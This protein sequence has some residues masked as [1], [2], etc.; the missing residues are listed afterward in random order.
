VAKI[1]T[2]AMPIQAHSFFIFLSFSWRK[3]L[4]D[5]LES[6]RSFL[7]VR[8]PVWSSP[9]EPEQVF[10]QSFSTSAMIS[11]MKVFAQSCLWSTTPAARFPFFAF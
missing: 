2:N 5:F 1:V 7:R 11:A 3:H 6:F 10:R 4:A 9:Q 8:E